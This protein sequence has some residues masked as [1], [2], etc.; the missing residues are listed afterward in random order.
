MKT[1]TCCYLESEW[2]RETSGMLADILLS[3][4]P[5]WDLE[6]YLEYCQ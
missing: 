2:Q 3:A 6:E 1:A 4:I 5:F